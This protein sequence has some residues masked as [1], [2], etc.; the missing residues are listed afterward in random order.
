MAEQAGQAELTKAALDK[1][2][3]FEQELAKLQRS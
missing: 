1:K 3:E 2:K